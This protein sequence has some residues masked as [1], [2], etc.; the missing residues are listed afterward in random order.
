MGSRFFCEPC[1][2]ICASCPASGKPGREI[3]VLKDFFQ[4]KW[5][6]VIFHEIGIFQIDPYKIQSFFS[7]V[8][9]SKIK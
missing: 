4:T 5:K 3:H 6:Y 2:Q 8:F 9:Y 1:F 7:V